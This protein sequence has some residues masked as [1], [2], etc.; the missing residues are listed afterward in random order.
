MVS[1]PWYCSRVSA[2]VICIDSVLGRSHISHH[3][4][5]C[6]VCCLLLTK[7]TADMHERWD[8]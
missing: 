1:Y 6:D 7:S 3:H 4:S 8:V 5:C 2:F